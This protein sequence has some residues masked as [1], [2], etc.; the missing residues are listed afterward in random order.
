MVW[1]GICIRL[2]YKFPTE[3]NSE[4]I[5]KIG[6]YLVKLWA[7][8]W[9]LVF[10][11]HSVVYYTSVD[12][13]LNSDLFWIYCTTCSTQL[14]SSWRDFDWHGSSRGL[15]A[16]VA[17]LLVYL[18]CTKMTLF[19]S[20]RRLRCLCF[21]FILLFNDFCQTN[22]LNIYWTDLHPVCWVGR[23]RA[24]YERSEVSF[25]IPRGMLLW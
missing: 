24:V 6:Q 16:A 17:E 15:S 8:V 14:C 23:T 3:S 19:I 22:Y 18:Q 20:P 4:R 1:W 11:T 7:R 5:W 9:C 13:M 25:L 12:L 10:L 2:C 21:I